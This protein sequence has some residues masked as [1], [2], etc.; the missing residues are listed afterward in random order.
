MDASPRPQSWRITTNFPYMLQFWMYVGQGE[1]FHPDRSD[2]T[3]QVQVMWAEWTDRL[4][5]ALVEQATMLSTSEQEPSTA[6][7]LHILSPPVF[8]ELAQTAELQEI[9]RRY[10]PEFT[11]YWDVRNGKHEV[12]GQ[13]LNSQFKRMNFNRMIRDSCRAAK[14]TTPQ[15]FHLHLDLIHWPENYQRHVSDT[16]L[17]LGA[18][19]LQAHRLQAFQVMLQT[20][21]QRLV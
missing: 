19:Y 10:W 21:I 16:H 14:K 5:A 6:H 13:Q 1:G 4:I 18:A 2:D 9:S 12:L 20:Y 8:Q 15:A 11:K 17:L 7:L 3:T